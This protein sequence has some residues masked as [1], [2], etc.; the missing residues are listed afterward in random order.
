MLA[1]S[2]VATWATWRLHLALVRRGEA[3]HRRVPLTAAVYVALIA[4]GLAVLPGNPDAITVPAQLVWRFRLASLAGAA[5]FNRTHLHMAGLATEHL[6]KPIELAVQGDDAAVK[7]VVAD[8]GIGI[9]KEKI[10]LVFDRFERAVPVR[11]YGGL[12]LGLYIARQLVEAHGG[13]IEVQSEPGQGATFIVHLPR[14]R[15]DVAAR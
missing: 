6:Q 14:W 9:S 11:K 4:L 2:L 5:A 8:R 15:P 3:E 1:W 12:G 7:L 10:A 13:R